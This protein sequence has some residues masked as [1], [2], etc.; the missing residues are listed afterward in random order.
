MEPEAKESGAKLRDRDVWAGIALMA[1]GGVALLGGAELPFMTRQGVGAGLLPRIVAGF[2]VALGALQTILA[3]RAP[4]G[5]VGAWAWR[6]VAIVLGAV[7]LFGL[8][9]RGGHIGPLEIPPLGLVVAGPL[10]VFVA[11]LADRGSR[12]GELIV[13]AIATSALCTAV[14]RFALGIPVPVAP[15]LIGY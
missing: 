5:A 8:T 3:L 7:V 4:G 10:A 11:G 1:V 12:P 14:F 15:W 2:I 9:I 13:F 6:E